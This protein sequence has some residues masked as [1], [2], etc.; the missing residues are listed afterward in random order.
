MPDSISP[1]PRA[2]GKA[3]YGPVTAG[4]GAYTPLKGRPPCR[5]VSLQTSFFIVSSGGTQGP[6]DSLQPGTLC[7]FSARFWAVTRP[8]D[9]FQIR[10][11]S[12]NQ[13]SP[14]MLPI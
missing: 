1:M 4:G 5:R 12:R 13:F 8:E 9:H 6:P 10:A 11:A 14:R 2:R 3:R 7:R